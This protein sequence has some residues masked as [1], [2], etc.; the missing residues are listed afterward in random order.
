MDSNGTTEKPRSCWEYWNCP[1]KVREKCY[2]HQ[3]DLGGF[4]WALEPFLEKAKDSPMAQHGFSSCEECPWYK[5][6][7]QLSE[8]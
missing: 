6:I 2:I 7:R 4:C 3:K 5:K 8:P 1:E